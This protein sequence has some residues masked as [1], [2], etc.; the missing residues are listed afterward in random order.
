MKGLATSITCERKNKNGRSFCYFVPKFIVSI[1]KTSR[2]AKQFR[3]SR[4]SSYELAYSKAVEYFCSS[5]GYSKVA[6]LELLDMIPKKE[7]FYFSYKRLWEAGHDISIE[8]VL[9]K[10]QM[11]NFDMTIVNEMKANWQAAKNKRKHK[12]SSS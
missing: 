12:K 6:E 5:L 10:L 7:I 1:G 8:E 4:N 11:S 2:D 3:I 9:D